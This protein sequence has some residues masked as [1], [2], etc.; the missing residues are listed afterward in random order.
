MSRSIHVSAI[1]KQEMRIRLY[2]LAL[3]TLARQLQEEEG[4]VA[5]PALPKPKPGRPK[6]LRDGGRAKTLHNQ[7]ETAF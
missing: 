7:R 4:Q 3:I 2:V 5:R 6:V 1:Y